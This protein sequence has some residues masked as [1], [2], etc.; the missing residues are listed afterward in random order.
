MLRVEIKRA[1]VQTEVIRPSNKPGAKQFAEF[2]KRYQIGYVLL[3]DQNGSPGDYPTQVNIGLQ[4][5]QAPYPPGMYTLGPESFYVDRNKNF[6]IGKLI[7]R[8]LEV[9]NQKVA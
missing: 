3:L 1:D 4:K 7:L 8:R 2:E 9:V 5:D 6:A